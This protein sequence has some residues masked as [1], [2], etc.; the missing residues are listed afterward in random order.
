MPILGQIANSAPRLTS[1]FGQKAIAV[2]ASQKSAATYKLAE[3]QKLQK[4]KICYENESFLDRYSLRSSKKERANLPLL[5]DNCASLLSLI[6]KL[7]GNTQIAALDG[8]DEL[9]LAWLALDWHE[10]RQV[11]VGQVMD[12]DEFKTR[13]YA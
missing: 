7:R 6:K 13:T 2:H 12:R 9:L 1:A 3:S 5:S 10:G 11:T 8:D 4:N